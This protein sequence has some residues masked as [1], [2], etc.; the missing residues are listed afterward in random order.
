[1]GC[2]FK[3]NPRTIRLH[4]TLTTTG[5]LLNCGPYAFSSGQPIKHACRRKRLTKRW[6]LCSPLRSSH[7]LLTGPRSTSYNSRR[8]VVEFSSSTGIKSR[9][10]IPWARLTVRKRDG[11]RPG[12]KISKDN[13]HS[14][15]YETILTTKKKTLWPESARE[16]YRPSDRHLLAKLVPTFA[17]RGCHVVRVTDPYGRILGVLDRTILTTTITIYSSGGYSTC[18]C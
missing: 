13:N 6:K 16:L 3:S 5:F 2:D 10:A 12:C 18:F 15:R 8:H 4:C 1:M 9:N 17:V 14:H 11:H 7:N